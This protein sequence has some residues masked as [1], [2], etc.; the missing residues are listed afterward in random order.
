MIA[1]FALVMAMISI[2]AIA[3][4]TRKGPSN[5]V[6]EIQPGPVTQPVTTK[7]NS[8]DVG[9]VDVVA[10][11]SKAESKVE[12]KV[13]Q[14]PLETL[15]TASK[16]FERKALPQVRKT[17]RVSRRK[18]ATYSDDQDLRSGPKQTPKSAVARAQVPTPVF[19]SKPVVSPLSTQL[20]SPPSKTGSKPKVI[21]WP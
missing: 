10:P 14:T 6:R 12:S 20:V 16:T 2:A 21:Q 7:S 9:P 3:L 11:E 19:T 17:A 4:L 1:A 15:A 18:S 5:D 8:V 13:D